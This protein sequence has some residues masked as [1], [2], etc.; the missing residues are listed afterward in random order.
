[1]WLVSPAAL[2]LSQ[3]VTF[4]DKKPVYLLQ[5]ETFGTWLGGMS[6]SVTSNG[7]KSVFL[8][9]IKT[10]VG[11]GNGDD[12]SFVRCGGDGSL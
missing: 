9:Q 2:T 12:G 1:M 5:I 7:Q 4:R 10:F 6:Q 3:S 8:L 11:G